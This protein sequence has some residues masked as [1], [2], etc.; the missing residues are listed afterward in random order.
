M[1]PKFHACGNYLT[2]MGVVKLNWISRKARRSPGSFMRVP[3]SM[4]RILSQSHGTGVLPEG[5]N[6]LGHCGNL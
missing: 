5:F 3:L 2:H 6:H 4:M 1:I